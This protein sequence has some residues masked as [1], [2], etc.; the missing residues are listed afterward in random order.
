MT[1]KNSTAQ[2]AL[3]EMDATPVV[4]DTDKAYE[5][6]TQERESAEY[7]R[8]SSVNIA[9]DHHKNNGGMLTI[10]QLVDNAKHIHAYIKGETQ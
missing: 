5:R 4:T 8:R 6:A 9:I 1:K 3:D 7:L 2:D 10:A